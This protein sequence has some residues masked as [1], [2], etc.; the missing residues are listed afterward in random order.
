MPSRLTRLAVAATL[1]ALPAVAHADT[2]ADINAIYDRLA[3]GLVAGDPALSRSTYADD[4]IFLP[5]QPVG[6]DRGAVV[7]DRMRQGA[8]RLKADGATM[9]ISYRVVSRQITGNLA[10]DAGYYR[11]DMT[12]PTGEPRSMTRYNKML[13]V[14]AKQ[15]DGSWKITHDASIAASQAAFDGAVAQPGLKFDK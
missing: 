4:A 2:N 5:A 14:S 13:V 10:I 8:E 11:T 7:H 6:I 3:A 9:K 15:K 12:R 1:A